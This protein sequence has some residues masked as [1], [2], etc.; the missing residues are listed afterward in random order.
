MFNYFYGDQ[1][2]QFNFIKIPRAMIADE[3][4]STLS[5]QAKILYSLFL[6]RMALSR[7]NSW[8]DD[9]NRVYIIYPITEIQSDLGFSRKKAMEYL[10]ELESFGLVEKRKRGFGLPS[11][12]YVK[13]F[14]T[15][16]IS[17]SIEIGTTEK[18]IKPVS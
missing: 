4:Y 3:M 12:I 10:A 14:L 9:D 8:F 17:R 16:D 11:I 5:L 18:V 6:D 7:K 1:A 13:N 2:D 15:Q